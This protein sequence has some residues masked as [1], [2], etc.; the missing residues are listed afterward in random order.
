MT[1]F[2][3]KADKRRG[4]FL[5]LIGDI[6]Y[7]LLTALDE[8]HRSGGLTQKAIAEKLSK[9][10]SWISRKLSGQSNMTLETLADLAYAM[11]RSIKV[12]L[13][14]RGTVEPFQTKMAECTTPQPCFVLGKSVYVNFHATTV[15]GQTEAHGVIATPIYILASSPSSG[16]GTPAVS[17]SVT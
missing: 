16:P 13:Q 5:R 3:L 11:N 1:S 4:A 2:S 10:K 6:R 8:E 17:G 15:N 14:P 7:A 12:S 9:N